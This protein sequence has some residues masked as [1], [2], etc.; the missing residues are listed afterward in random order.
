E[1][2]V[3]PITVRAETSSGALVAQTSQ[4]LRVLRPP[5][6]GSD[7]VHTLELSNNYSLSVPASGGVAPYTLSIASGEIP[8]GMSLDSMA[9]TGRPLVHGS[10]T[11]DLRIV[12]A[13]GR[14]D[15]ARWYL[16]VQNGL[17][18]VSNE[19]TDAY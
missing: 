7:Q 10:Y 6:A 12:D 17:S 18:I 3:F 1:S 19:I 16:D 5:F 2:G 4:T 11:A 13:N 9:V 14:T 15:T 8:P